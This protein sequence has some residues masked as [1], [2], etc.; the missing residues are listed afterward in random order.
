MATQ[1]DIV[2]LAGKGH[3]QAIIGPDGPQPW[4]E[5]AEAEAALRRAGFG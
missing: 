1:G 5:R 3:E 4:D 2:L